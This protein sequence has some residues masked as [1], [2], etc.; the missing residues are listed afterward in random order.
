MYNQF[1]NNTKFYNARVR[2]YRGYHYGPIAGT[3]A[4]APAGCCG[5]PVRNC[6]CSK[7]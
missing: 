4:L 2:D 6:D 5:K 3:V 7:R 1:G